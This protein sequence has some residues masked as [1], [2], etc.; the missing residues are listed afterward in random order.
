[1]HFFTI[2]PAAA[3]PAFIIF[4]GFFILHN[5]SIFCNASSS[6]FSCIPSE[7][8]ALLSFKHD[9]HDPALRLASWVGDDCCNWSGVVCSELTPHHVHKLLLGDPK[10]WKFYDT[11]PLSG[12]IN[13]SLVDLKHLRHLDLSNSDIGGARIPE[14][15]GSLVSL[16]YLNLSGTHFNGMIPHQLGNLTNLHSLDLNYV[17]TVINDPVVHA[18]AKNLQWLS[19]LSSLRYLDMS[20]VDLEEA[21]DWLEVTNS[22][23]SLE[24]LRLSFCNLNFIFRPIY[25]VNF[26]SLSL[27]DLSYNY[28]GNNIP[29]WVCNLRSLTSLYLSNI[30]SGN[31]G[32]I[33][34]DIQNL[35]SLV[36]L[37][38]SYNFFNT[39]IPSWLYSLSHLEVLI[40]SYNEF[41]GPIPE[42]I[43]NLTSLVHLD[44]SGNFFNTSIPSW[45]YSLSH[46]EILNLQEN[47]L[48][49]TISSEIKNMTSIITLDLSE[50]ELQG[51]LPTSS[52]AQ[53][54]KLKE[55]DLSG[56][57]WNRSISQILDSCSGCLSDS[58][59]VLRLTDSQIYGPLTNK[60]GQFKTL[61]YFDLSYNS[62]SGPIPA[63]FGNL[64]SLTFLP[65]SSNSISGSIPASLGNLSSLTAL[66]LS[67]NSIS[68]PIPASLGNLSSLTYLELSSNSIS[69]PIPASLGNLS[70]LTHLELYSN[71][72][73][74]PIPASLG[75][76]SS[77]TH[78]EL[79][80]N[81]ISGP[82]PAS[83]GNLSSLTTVSLAN[84]HISETLPESLGQLVNLE[85]L[86]ID[87]NQIEG[88]VSEAHFANT[89]SLRY[90]FA[91]DNPLTLKVG[92]DWV[93]PFQ[94]VD[95]SMG[96]CHLG[97]KLPMWVRSQKSLSYLVLSNTSLADV[98]PAWIFNF[99]SELQY[100]DLSQNQMHGRIP[101][102]T[103]MGTQEYS[104]IDLSQNHFEGPLPLVSSK[105]YKL[106]LSDNLLSGSIS[107]FLC[108]SPSE[109]MN[110][111]AL[112]LAKN[113]LSGKLPNCWSKWKNIQVLYLNYNSF[114]GGIPSSFG[115]LIFLQSLHLRGNNLSGIL[116]L[117]V[118]QN[119][120]NLVTLDLSGNKFGG[121]VPTW[122]GT[123]PSKLRFLIAGFNE[124]HG[125]IPD[126]LC[127]LNSLQ[128]LD[129]SNN[130]LSGPIPKC[131]NNF[132]I[133][134]IKR[135]ESL[136]FGYNLSRSG[137]AY[138]MMF[139]S[140]SFVEV[141]NASYVEAALLLI[142]GKPIEYT[143][144]LEFVNIIDLSGNSLSGH[145]PLEITN[146][147]NLLSLNLSNNLL[148]G[149]IPMRIGD[150]RELESIDFSMNNLS[151]EIPQ[152]MSSLSFLSY[153]NLSY[154]NLSGKIP[155]G[156]Q[157]Q[158]FSSSSFVG[159]KLCGPPLTPNCS[160]NGE[161]TVVEKNRKKDDHEMSWFYIGMA[162]GFIVGFWGFCGSLIFN[163]TWRHSYFRFLDCIKDQIYVASVLKLRWFRETITSCYNNQ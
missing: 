147:L 45:L 159:N 97:P 133:M 9:L 63:S 90:F 118:L 54:C 125:H 98:L 66:D 50:N 2:P 10:P 71:S 134:A 19:Q 158:S 106:D 51:D 91:S 120:I 138:Y 141:G 13:P 131:F 8:Q 78:L 65:L 119:C 144:T 40:L 140:A 70:S 148:D 32:P 155:T 135:A 77:L 126:E 75:N 69:G 130:N 7:R 52:I 107:Q 58:L 15:L 102:L 43:Q 151:G 114:G 156:T 92:Q 29:P 160:T 28:L 145:I 41:R 1:M 139:G 72:I 153:L 128:I 62:I 25:H 67:S 64:S 59:Q 81:S 83:L 154:N 44:L 143:N 11:K 96:S 49:G 109:P 21:S 38:L 74:G 23:P 39:S 33:P 6:N 12:E 53:L 57:T 5:N 101:N 162:V 137:S 124:F 17:Y 127:A 121:N 22:L 47:Q 79:S 136:G 42:D 48:R 129:L 161:V 80:Y 24:V 132:S 20:R 60:I 31:G 56:N 16:R 105:V 30:T 115:S 149:E 87:K 85:G 108:S 117:S 146:L 36:H 4:F 150:M 95:L 99:S 163:R 26:S 55:I 76:L 93:P 34:E 88:I 112:D 27:L 18:Y 46:L 104:K 37:D 73:S 89:T 103:D 113:R 110:M 123:S 3:A 111:I 100:L 68:G 61:T 82:I 157:L 122:L 116:S 142:K 94:L 84:N 152:S 86:D 35:T 14:F